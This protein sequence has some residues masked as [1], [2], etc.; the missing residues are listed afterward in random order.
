MWC[1]LACFSLLFLCVFHRTL[2]TCCCWRHRCL[3]HWKCQ[4]DRWSW[5]CCYADW[6]KCS[7]NFWERLVL[8][9]NKVTGFSQITG[10]ILK[11]VPWFLCIAAGLELRPL[12]EVVFCSPLALGQLGQSHCRRP[13]G[14]AS[15]APICYFLGDSPAELTKSGLVL[16][17]TVLYFQGKMMEV[18]CYMCLSCSVLPYLKSNCMEPYLKGLKCDQNLLGTRCCLYPPLC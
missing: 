8:W 2:C 4:A 13:Q 1:I 6:S 18:V 16:N 12:S 3:C 15:D 14:T 5:C 9:E 17:K 11:P 10:S 7:I